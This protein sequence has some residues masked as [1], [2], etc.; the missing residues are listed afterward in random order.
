MRGV[1]CGGEAGVSLRTDLPGP[2]PGPDEVVVDVLMAGICDTDLQLARG[3]MGYRGVLG[4]EFVGLAPDG[5]RVTAE[6]NNAFHDCATCRAGRPGHC[7]NRTVL[8]ILNHNGAMADRVAVPARNLHD[9]PDA[10]SDRH[11]VLIEPLAAAFRMVEQT[12]PGVGD[13]LAVVGDGKLGLLCAWV[14]RATGAEVHLVGKHRD[15]LALAGPGVVTHELSEM[16]DLGRSSDI[17]V[18]ATGSTTGL[19]TAL[20]LV[21]PCGTV[22]LKTTVAGPHTIDLSPI[23]IDEV[24]L[25]GSRCGPFERAITALS[26]GEIDVEPL[27]GAIYS[28]NDA[29]AAFRAAATP[30]ARKVIL[31]V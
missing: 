24:R 30:G 26:H 21:R 12:E 22:V 28:L 15:K 1:W 25:I 17:V 10:I 19:P 9:V 16:N 20:G 14:A 5:R 27:I 3:Y 23:V 7:P 4:H 18:D 11:A 31:R 2:E 13:R 6:I 29:E 8:G